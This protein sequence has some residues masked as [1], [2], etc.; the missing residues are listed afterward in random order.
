MS[1]SVTTA[2]G[3][4]YARSPMDATFGQDRFA[5]EA[6]WLYENCPTGD[7]GDL[8]WPENTGL[9]ETLGISIPDG[10]LPSVE[11]KGE[12]ENAYEIFCRG[13]DEFSATLA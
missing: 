8:K 4:D 3:D 2:P 13:L 9:A 7:F 5:H 6:E 12:F 1:A 10:G 11:S